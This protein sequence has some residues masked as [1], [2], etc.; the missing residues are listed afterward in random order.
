MHHRDLLPVIADCLLLARVG[1]ARLFVDRQPIEVR[2][3][4][5]RRPF[6]ILQDRDEA[7]PADPGGDGEAQLLHS[8]GEQR[9]RL[10]F[11]ARQLRLLVQLN[12]QRVEI[13]VE[14]VDG[15]CGAE[16]QQQGRGEHDPRTYRF[17]SRLS[18]AFSPSR[19]A[20]AEREARTELPTCRT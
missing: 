20:G 11:V 2:S 1:Q 13:R 4:Q 9:G 12:V 5:H 3:H 14:D 17:A 16:Q 7:E 8:F 18:C 6:A 19:R 15:R 10:L